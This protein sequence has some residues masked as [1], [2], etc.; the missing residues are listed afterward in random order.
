MILNSNM[1]GKKKCFRIIALNPY[2]IFVP[3]LYHS[4]NLIIRDIAS[5]SIHKMANDAKILFLNHF[6]TLIRQLDLVKEVYTQVIQNFNAL[7]KLIFN[8]NNKTAI[9]EL[10]KTLEFN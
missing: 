4:L 1:E 6:V 9:S 3:C 8:N 10:K 7:E 5:N 2:V